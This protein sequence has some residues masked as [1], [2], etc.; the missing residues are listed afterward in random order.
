MRSRT[1]GPLRG[2]ALAGAAAAWFIVACG[3]GNSVETTSHSSAAD[4]E[5]LD[6]TGQQVVFWY[7]H[8]RERET[9]LQEMIATYN[10]ANP[11]GITVRG[12]YAGDYNDIY[13]KMIVAL[14][15]GSVPD[16]VVAYQNQSLEYFR[17]D[18]VIDLTPYMAS[19]KW[20]LDAQAEADYVKAFLQQDCVDGKQIALP[21]N[22]SIEVLYYN[23][24]WL[25]ELGADGPPTTWEAFADLCRAARDRPFSG[26][27]GRKR[28]LGFILDVDASRLATMVFSRGGSLMDAAGAAYTLDSP[29]VAEA[30]RLMQVLIAEGAAQMMGEAYGDQTAFSAGECLFILRSTS[31]LPYVEAG[32]KSGAAFAWSVAAPPRTTADPVVNV[33]GASVSVGRTTAQRQLAAWLFLKWFTEPAQQARWVKASNYFPARRS[34]RALLSDY[35]E[36]NPTFRDAY[37][38]LDYGRAEPSVAGYEGVRRLISQELVK[39]IEGADIAS[40]LQRLQRQANATLERE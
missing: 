36:S 27:P 20:G 11:F 13:N 4:L 3:G 1:R 29:Q 25:R 37:G 19:P 12:E 9:A 8:T 35:F 18:G 31:G 22:R 40:T 23:V 28:S 26:N 7:Q 38:L 5:A 17:A 39:V 16:L 30:L 15:S 34:T 10:G 14:Q 32:V 24:D 6:P 33:Y 2:I 21:P